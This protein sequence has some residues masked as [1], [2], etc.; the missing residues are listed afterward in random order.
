MAGQKIR[1]RLKAY[2]HE[3]IDSSARKIVETVTR[4]GAQV[5]GPVPLPTEKN[6][7]CVIRSPHK[8]KDS[9][10]RCG[11]PRPRSS[12]GRANRG[13]DRSSL[14]TGWC[15]ASRSPRSLRLAAAREQL[16]QRASCRSRWAR[17]CTSD[18][19]AAAGDRSQKIARL[20]PRTPAKLLGVEH[21]VAA[22]R[23]FREAKAHA[24]G[25]RP[26]VFGVA[27]AIEL[28]QH[29]AARL[30]L[31]GL[32]P[33]DVL[34][35][36]VF[37]L[38]DEARLLFGLVAA[39]ARDPRRAPRGTACRAGDSCGTSFCRAPW[40]LGHTASKNARSCE[41]TST[42][43]RQPFRYVASQSIVSKSRWLVGSSRNEQLGLAGQHDAE[44]KTARARHRT[45][46]A[47]RAPSRAA[48]SR[49]AWRSSPRAARAGR[50]P[51]ADSDPSR[52]TAARA[53][54]R[55]RWPPLLGRARA[56][57]AASA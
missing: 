23:S 57:G 36:E 18:H 3:V 40:W 1:I 34:A 9:R 21:D 53:R 50:R 30:R 5:A 6:V 8:Y 31:L 33:R 20:S 29:A 24:L 15:R 51:R 14:R 17:R 54:S 2:D 25:A 52:S 16:E 28:V 13:A 44:R 38:G 39:R 37:G 43:P 49:A 26:N 19:R 35:D 42:A 46:C 22:A 7:Y 4:T 27:H 45:R 32:L 47:R 56:R 10:A 55:R 11:F 41:T 12:A 48:R